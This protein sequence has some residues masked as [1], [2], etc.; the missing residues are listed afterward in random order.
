MGSIAHQ[1]G[2]PVMYAYVLHTFSFSRNSPPAPQDLSFSGI[3]SKIP[4][5]INI[6]G[7]NQ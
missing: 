5:H 7:M 1:I 3:L 6:G 2:L 4:T